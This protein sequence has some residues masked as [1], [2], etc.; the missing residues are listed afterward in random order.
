MLAL[1]PRDRFGGLLQ[2][3]AFEASGF[4]RTVRTNGRWRLVTPE[5]HQFFSLGIDA[6]SPDAG[7]DLYNG[8][9]I[10]VRGIT[11]GKNDPLAAHFGNAS[12]DLKVQIFIKA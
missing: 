5:G 11:F 8:Q 1:P 6:L 2:G 9:G 12:S 3:P 7:R 10:H 4:F